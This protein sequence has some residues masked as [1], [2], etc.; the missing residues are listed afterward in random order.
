MGFSALGLS[1]RGILER[2]FIVYDTLHAGSQRRATAAHSNSNSCPKH[3]ARLRT[4]GP[5]GHVYF[6]EAL[7]GSTGNPT[8]RL[9][10]Y[11]ALL[12]S[13]SRLM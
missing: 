12:N 4:E 6:E 2:G 13:A 5:T 1:D 11:W 9:R 7:A 10:W 8:D 3:G